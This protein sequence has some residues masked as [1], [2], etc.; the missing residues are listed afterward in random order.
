MRKVIG[1][2][3]VL[4]ACASTGLDC[5]LRGNIPTTAGTTEAP[6]ANEQDLKLIQEA[7]EYCRLSI[8]QSLLLKG[9]NPKAQNTI[10][11]TALMG[12]SASGNLDAVKL[13]LSKGADPRFKN[14]VLYTV[15]MSA[16]EGGSASIVNLLLNNGAKVD[17]NAQDKY[18][19][20]ALIYAARLGHFLVVKALLGVKD[21]NVNA[22]ARHGKTALMEAKLMKAKLMKAKDPNFS[23]FSKIIS[24]LKAA[25]AK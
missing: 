2:V 4:L 9:A 16:S 20:T 1:L 24:A 18:G 7:F 3:I 6:L 21:I 10:G 8:L 14:T 17:V 19:F 22:Q 12:A 5:S 15:L 23:N 11:N 25:G 13:L